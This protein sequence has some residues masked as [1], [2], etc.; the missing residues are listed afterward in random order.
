M[1]TS[2]ANHIS[3]LPQPREGDEM[4]EWENPYDEE[5]QIERRDQSEEGQ[6]RRRIFERRR[7]AYPEETIDKCFQE[8]QNRQPE[9]T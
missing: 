2:A 1:R 4:I 9:K 8:G 7:G 6:S 5:Y 3:G